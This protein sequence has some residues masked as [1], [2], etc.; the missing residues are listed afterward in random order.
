VR[1]PKNWR[2]KLRTVTAA[3][4]NFAPLQKV[5]QLE[6]DR[7]AGRT[8]RPGKAWTVEAWLMHWLDN[9]AAP[10]VRTKT[11]VGYETAIRRHLIPGLGKHRTDRL[12]PEYIETLY[13]N[14]RKKDL[15]PATIHQVHRTLR[16]ALNEAVRRGQL[17]ANPVLVAKAPRL[18]EEE[19]EPFTLPEAQQILQTALRQRNGLRFALALT[20]GLRQGEA[21]GLQWRDVNLDTGTLTIRRAIQRH[22]WKHG[23]GGGC[24]GKRGADCPQRHGGGLAVVPTK[25]RS[26]RREVGIPSQ[27]LPAFRQHQQTQQEERELAANVWEEGGWVFAQPNG[28][29]IDARRDHGD[30][31]KLL[32]SA[33]VRLARLHDARHTAATMLLVLKVPT[34]AVM[35]VMGWSQPS[36]TTRYQHVPAEV[37]ASIAEQVGSLLWH[38]ERPVEGAIETA[39]ETTEPNEEVG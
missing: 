32:A 5:R 22:S 30:W 35:D 27:L 18:I 33:G 10:S 16:A 2:E 29:P 4:I 17:T 31:R 25:S 24:S 36:M 20:M 12:Q 34:R 15:K 23:C 26:G 38:A 11:L 13:M 21:L 7:E 8:K 39:S 6:K 37:R 1:L 9:I 19:I 3:L 28:R 14:M